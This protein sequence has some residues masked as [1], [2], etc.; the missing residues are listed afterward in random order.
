MNLLTRGLPPFL[1]CSS[2]GDKR[3]SAF[4]ATPKSLD[5]MTIEEAYQRMKIL[6]LGVVVKSGWRY[7]KGIR[8][9]NAAECAE[10]YEKWWREWI[11]EKQLIGVL[12]SASG[13]SDMFGRETGV[14]QA[15]VLWRIR[16][17]ALCEK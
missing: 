9:V 4:Y 14:C 5:G 2:R 16:Q 6:P 1:E 12:K 11:E 8:A 13:L 3:F 10:A 7:K 15:D 17:E